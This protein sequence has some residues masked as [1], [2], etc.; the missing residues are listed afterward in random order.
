[1]NQLFV[2]DYSAAAPRPDLNKRYVVLEPRVDANGNETSGVRMPELSTPLATY[3]GWNLRAAGHAAPENCF[4]TGSAIPLAISA[5]AKARGDPRA[6][7]ADLYRGRADY[8]A[9]FDAVADRLVAQGFLT[10]LD[11]D[12]LYKAGAAKIS[13]ALI[14]AP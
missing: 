12:T 1:V 9:K 13:P 8:E 4:Y 5:A 2:T 10:R 7:L 14:P 11:A 6:T 3:T